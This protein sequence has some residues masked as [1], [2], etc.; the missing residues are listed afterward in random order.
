MRE[1]SDRRTCDSSKPRRQNLGWNP[2]FDVRGRSHGVRLEISKLRVGYR[3]LG[4]VPGEAGVL[5]VPATSYLGRILHVRHG[6][7]DRLLWQSTR[8]LTHSRIPD[9]GEFMKTDWSKKSHGWRG[10]RV[11]GKFFQ[12]SRYVSLTSR[13]QNHPPPKQRRSILQLPAFGE[14]V[15]SVRTP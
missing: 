5:C 6:V 13:S 9:Q 7:E 12:N 15:Y 4:H 1:N 10:S 14:R 8:E 11:S 2:V 3:K